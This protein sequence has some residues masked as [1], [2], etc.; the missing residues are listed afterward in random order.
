MNI[1]H[2]SHA[3]KRSPLNP[4]ILRQAAIAIAVGL[5][6]AVLL[7]RSQALNVADHNRYSRAIVELSEVDARLNQAVLQV[8]YGLLNNY[9]PLVHGF[10]DQ[11]T[12]QETLKHLPHFI[13][14][15]DQQTL[16]QLLQ[17]HNEALQQKEQW[18][19]TFKSNN[20]ILKNSLAYFPIAITNVVEKIS[21]RALTTSLNTL[22][23]DILIYNLSASE[24]LHDPIQAQLAAIAQQL[25]FVPSSIGAELG[26]A[27]AHARIIV[28][29]KS[30]VYTLVD[31]I[32]KMPLL[33]RTEAIFRA[34]NQYYQDALNRTTGYRFWLYLVSI[35]LT[36]YIASLIIGQLRQAAIALQREQER[37][38][39]LLLNILPEPIAERLKNDQQSIAESFPDVTVLFADIVGFTQLAGHIPPTD[40]VNVL[41]RIFSAFDLLTERY[42]LEKI[43]TIGDAYMVVGGLPHHRP[44]HAEAIAAMALDM[45]AEIQRFNAEYQETF[46]IRIGINTG[47]VVA[48][49]IGIKKFIYDLWGDTVNIASRM[50]SQGI[51][52]RIQVSEATYKHLQT[53]F[54]FGKRGTIE[55][56]GKG[57]MTTYLLLGRA[58]TL[59]AANPYSS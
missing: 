20:A 32:I 6:V 31:S 4:K 11:Q 21:D 43:K 17:L 33:E 58:K 22:L 30:R 45:Q 15:K 36:I 56:K 57:E 19:E 47:P 44:D 59:L 9:D 39:R 27:L 13:N 2:P 14:L 24:V 3:G 7:L 48:G 18:V 35:I 42:G 49:V 8:R 29:Q 28:Q 40:L 12:L 55:V 34:Y 16:K 41:N 46:K 25:P 26:V 37:A 10:S 52:G 38:E 23:Q 1:A 51:A 54:L 5:L 53:K 50:E